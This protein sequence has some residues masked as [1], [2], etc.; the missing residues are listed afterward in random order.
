MF[1]F[2][3]IVSVLLVVLLLPY[4]SMPEVQAKSLD[5][6]AGA[7]RTFV[8][9]YIDEVKILGNIGDI[10]GQG[11]FRL[12][13]LAA[14]TSG[15][16]SGMF[17]PGKGPVKVRRGDTVT[18]PCLLAVSFDEAKVSDGVY[19]AIIAIDEDKSSL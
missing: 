12:I 11:E 10:A 19:L 17:C 8:N 7:S 16:S 3:S 1:R 5:S 13:V 6:E 18:A 4:G 2:R 15:K 14:D 9:L